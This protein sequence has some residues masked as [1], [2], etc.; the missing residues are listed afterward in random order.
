MYCGTIVKAFFDV[1]AVN[2][3]GCPSFYSKEYREACRAG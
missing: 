3:I 1:V 2:N